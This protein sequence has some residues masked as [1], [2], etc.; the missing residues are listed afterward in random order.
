MGAGSF[1]FLAALSHWGPFGAADQAAW[2][3]AQPGSAV[4][5]AN[6]AVRVQGQATQSTG[7]HERL[8][9]QVAWLR[10]QGAGA[11]V[12]EGWF[13]EAPQADLRAFAEELRND[14]GF[15]PS[16]A[17]QPAL[18]AL[19][20]A[21][22]GLDQ[23]LRLA[24]S[25]GQAQP[26][27]LAFA[28]RRGA[29]QPLPGDLQKQGYEVTLRGKRQA[30]TPRRA[31]RLPYAGLLAAVARSGAVSLDDPAVRAV[32]AT[33]E[34]QGRWFNSLGLEAARL[35]LGVPLEG[36][37]YRWRNGRLS[38][39]ELKGVRYP[40]ETDGRLRL[41]ENL[42]TLAS[43]ELE[44]LQH[45]PQVSA[46]L[47]GKAVFF[48]PWPQA[49]SDAGAFD[50]QERLFAAVVERS[51][52][53]PDLGWGAWV[54]WVLAWA[55]AVLALAWAP[56]YVALLAWSLPIIWLLRG[57]SQDP[58][59]LAQPLS[60][61]LSALALGLGWR[62]QVQRRRKAAAELRF[63]GHVSPQNL[64]AWQKRLPNQ[65]ASLTGT[66]ASLSPASLANEPSFE[67]WLRT[68]GAF[69]DLDLGPDQLGIF[70]PAKQDGAPWSAPSL[71]RLLKALPR[72]AIGA[73]PGTL[74][75][76]QSQR[77]G[78]IRW[79]IEGLARQEA[80]SLGLLAKKG[81]F[82]I[83]ERDYASWHGKLRIQLTGAS[84]GTK[85]SELKVLNVLTEPD[86]SR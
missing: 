81:Q 82:L 84:I 41:P 44:A 60:L 66:Y 53:V 61:A 43:L 20:K 34:L 72:A 6:T 58:Q 7:H 49:L 45:D 55:V 79:H 59:A 40:L 50:A 78:A 22:S 10:A 18:K 71:L 68:Q 32:P 86:P 67:A 56:S 64:L 75:F 26:L 13:D 5:L 33:V 85:E 2:R 3:W 4:T 47:K 76:V 24:Q 25:L 31:E 63:Q 15:L 30:L 54:F 28:I 37:R 12:L 36:L 83:L 74:S 70:V 29:E 80:Q 17:R 39:L 14:F 77:L 23:D 1:L 51:V 11:I 21:A 19:A 65:G 46:K 35:A 57:F 62:L 8:A 38:T 69:M 27:V 16:A 9:T 73:V 48:R 52:L 42:P